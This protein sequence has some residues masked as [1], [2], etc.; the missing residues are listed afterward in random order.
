LRAGVMLGCILAASIW[1]L[2]RASEF[3]YFQF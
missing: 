2:T 3:L 1:S